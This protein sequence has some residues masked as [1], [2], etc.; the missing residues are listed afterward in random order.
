MFFRRSA[1]GSRDIDREIEQLHRAMG[2]AFDDFD[3]ELGRQPQHSRRKAR[4]PRPGIHPA[5]LPSPLGR[6]PLLRR[7]DARPR[8]RASQ[9]PTVLDRRGRPVRSPGADARTPR[10]ADRLRARLRAVR[11]LL[12]NARDRLMGPALL[13]AGTGLVI[14]GVARVGDRAALTAAVS[15]TEVA[16]GA[17]LDA[18]IDELAEAIATAE[19][20]FAIGPYDGRTLPHVLNN[21]GAL[22]KPALLASDLPTWK[23]TGLVQ[24][25]TAEM[26][27]EALRHQVRLMLTGE[28]RIYHASDTLVHVGQKYADGDVNWGVNVA[29]T[30][31]VTPANTL[32]DLTPRE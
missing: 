24:F 8:Q 14:G 23:D 25:P 29:T 3:R 31:G 30:L 16:A 12:Q 15:T 21:P 19:G 7:R 10:F 18:R 17:A 32:S 28:S 20:Y 26:G 9:P 27:W 1:S 2:R 22:K 13:L 4:Q 6:R 5:R 11:R